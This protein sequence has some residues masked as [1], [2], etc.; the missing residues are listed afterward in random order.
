MTWLGGD[1]MYRRKETT[2]ESEFFFFSFDFSLIVM[3]SHEINL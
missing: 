1:W 3:K 2:W